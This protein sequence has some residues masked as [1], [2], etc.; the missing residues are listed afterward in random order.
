MDGVAG[1]FSLDD[2]ELVQNI[3]LATGALQ[4][5]GKTCAGIAIG[6]GKGLYEHK[7][8]GRM[9]NIIDEDLI[10]TYQDLSPVAA[11]GNV[12]YTKNKYPAAI[13]AEP[14]EIHPR[15]HS[16]Y[17]ILLTL[18]GYLIKED[19]LQAELNPDYY[20]ETRN[21]TEVIGALLHKYI[22]EEG[23]SF[24]AGKKLIDKLHGRTTLA[25]VALVYDVNKKETSML[26]LNDDRAF[27]PF[28]YSTI[29]DTFVVSS[30][31]CSP[32]RLG[33]FIDREFDGAEMAICSSNGIE[34]K[35]LRYETLLPDIFQG[36]YFGHVASL[37]RGKENFQIRR[38]LGWT[39]VDY[40]GLS[41]VDIV[42]PNPDSGWG[43]TMGVFE[44]T[45]AKLEELAFDYSQLSEGIIKIKDAE[46]YERYN[47]LVTVYPALV[48][49]AQAVRT[50]QEGEQ[51]RRTVE[52]GLKFGGIDSLLKDKKVWDGD[53]SI[54]K[55]SVSE[56]GS[57]WTVKNSGAKEHGWL[58]SYG[59]MVFPSFKEWNRGEDCVSELAVQ[60][61]FKGDN[62]YNKSLEE[63]NKAVAE[64][65]KLDWVRYN[66]QGRIEK[67]TGPGS[68]QA[69]DASY[70]ISE[71]FR[72]DFINKEIEKYHKYN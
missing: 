4:H 44:A 56:G 60:R 53:D 47:S 63:I 25:M 41:D 27:E 50:F 28:C 10:R 36:V 24:N 57:V 68:F 17:Q 49:Q 61:A 62:P 33:G 12:G 38:E 1:I 54:V 55:G 52:V 11:I 21:K 69:L 15:R 19:D 48:K 7:G 23:I 13:N 26:S 71:E 18:D 40:Y 14:I 22:E 70:P 66:T 42:I 39:L 59:P 2:N 43:V 31:S 5:R 8:L 32:R 6:N 20:F 37:F 51:R 65:I 45:K 72:P 3:F 58:V 9:G 64:L 16:Q 35:R 29:G 34:I 46:A 30:E 67:I